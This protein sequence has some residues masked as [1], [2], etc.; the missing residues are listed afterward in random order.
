MVTSLAH[1]ADEFLCAPLALRSSTGNM[2]S[3][4]HLFGCFFSGRAHYYCLLSLAFSFGRTKPSNQF[5]L[6]RRCSNPERVCHA[7][8][9][10]NER[11]AAAV[12]FRPVSSRGLRGVV[13]A[14]RRSRVISSRTR[15]RTCHISRYAAL[16]D[17]IA[18]Q[19]RH[20]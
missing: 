15:E 10:L 9:F 18:K 7:G 19:Q 20:L 6:S 1:S 8:F 12:R 16:T 3:T 14:R 5:A 13:A 2:P 4:I 17:S 11:L